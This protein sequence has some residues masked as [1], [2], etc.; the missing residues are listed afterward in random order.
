[1]HC[2]SGSTAPNHIDKST[3]LCCLYRSSGGSSTNEAL[4]SH[5]FNFVD[6]DRLTPFKREKMNSGRECF[7]TIKSATRTIKMQYKIGQVLRTAS[8]QKALVDRSK[9]KIG[10]GSLPRSNTHSRLRPFP[11][12]AKVNC[13]NITA[14]DRRTILQE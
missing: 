14:H 9:W 2:D 12:T 1:M 8:L 13:F 3:M 6:F 5:S 7:Q 4:N 11:D 10:I